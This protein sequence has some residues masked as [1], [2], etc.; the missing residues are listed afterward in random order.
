[1]VHSDFCTCGTVTVEATG[2]PATVSM[3]HWRNAEGG[4]AVRD[5]VSECE[6]QRSIR[7]EGHS[8]FFF[9]RAAFCESGRQPNHPNS[10]KSAENETSRLALAMVSRTGSGFSD[11]SPFICFCS[12]CSRLEMILASPHR[13]ACN[14]SR[15]GQRDE[16]VLKRGTNRADA[17]PTPHDKA[18]GPKRQAILQF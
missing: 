3:C 6:R 4:E 7:A 2:D 1:M 15:L 17:A 11:Q 12:L 9:A 5:H 8:S 18:N 14:V 13:L 16:P 10:W